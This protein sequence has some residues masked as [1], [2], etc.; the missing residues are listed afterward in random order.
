VA[1]VNR[2][3]KNSNF[4]VPDSRQPLKNQGEILSFWQHEIAKDYSQSINSQKVHTSLDPIQ[5]AK[6]AIM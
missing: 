2:S 3:C 1:R 5:I 6:L 4:V